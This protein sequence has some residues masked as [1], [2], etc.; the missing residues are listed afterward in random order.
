M[1]KQLILI[2][3]SN[4][5]LVQNKNKGEDRHNVLLTELIQMHD[6]LKNNRRTEH[7]KA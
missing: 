6:L 4:A 2:G 1:K 3:E 5:F 7:N